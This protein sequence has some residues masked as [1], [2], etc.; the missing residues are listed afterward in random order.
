MN[1]LSVVKDVHAAV[2]RSLARS[3]VHQGL[4]VTCSAGCSHCCSEAAYVERS[5]AE[6]CVATIP[7]AELPGVIERLKAWVAN[8]KASRIPKLGEPH[9]LEYLAAGLACPLLKGGLCLVY[10]DRPYACR[11]HCALGSPSLCSSP[12]TR[13]EQ[14]YTYSP[15]LSDL[16]FMDFMKQ[17]GRIHFDHL[18]CL[19][20]EILLG[21]RLQSA[22]RVERTL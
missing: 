22:A 12:E 19:L 14:R 10:K 20:S 5:E 6:A 2:D 15:E 18:G 8:Y 3:I 4:T 21:E 11:G 1:A 17:L 7:A 9:V 16:V 13:L